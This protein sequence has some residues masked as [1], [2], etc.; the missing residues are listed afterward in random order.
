MAK[1]IAA[2][3]KADMAMDKAKG[4]KEG[5]KKDIALDKKAGVYSYQYGKKVK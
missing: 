3:N 1:S 2:R 4:V 5:S